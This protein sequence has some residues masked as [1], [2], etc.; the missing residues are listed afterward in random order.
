MKYLLLFAIGLI[1]SSCGDLFNKDL[2]GTNA[3]YEQFATCE[4]DTEAFSYILEKNIRGDILCLKENLHLFMDTV[5]S[6]NPGTIS[7]KTLK[8][9][10]LEG[11][12]DVDPDT[13]D[14]IDSVFE[15]SHILLG[16]ERE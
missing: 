16:T 4:M 7:K 3:D 9:F 15:I 14:I 1:V 8:E 11:P 10:V 13:V 2:G 12:I 6:D 5:E